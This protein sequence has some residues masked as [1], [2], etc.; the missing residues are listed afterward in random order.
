MGMKDMAKNGEKFDLIFLDADKEN[1]DTYYEICLSGADRNGD[2][3][4]DDGILAN[5]GVILADNS[6]CALLYDETDER[7]KALHRFNRRVAMDVRVEQVLLTVREGITMIRRKNEK[8]RNDTESVQVQELGEPLKSENSK[9]SK[10]ISRESVHYYGRLASTAHIVVLTTILPIFSII[11]FLI[12]MVQ[13][14]IRNKNTELD[15]ACKITYHTRLANKKQITMLIPGAHFGKTLTI[16]RSIKAV[17]PNVRIILTDSPKYALN[18]ARFSRY[19]DAFEIVTAD[20]VTHPQEYVCELAAIA[21][22]H[23]VT[24]FLPVSQPAASFA[25][26][27]ACEEMTKIQDFSAAYHVPAALCEILDDKFLFCQI[28]EEL[29]K[30]DPAIT[31]PKTVLIETENG[32]RAL[33]ANLLNEE[34]KS[35]EIIKNLEY[36]CLHRLDLFTMP[37]TEGALGGYLR[38]LRQ[39]GNGICS[40]HPWIAQTKLEGNEYSAA[41]VIRNS[42]VKLLTITRSSASQL[43]FEHIEHQGIEK[44]VYAFVKQCN[45]AEKG[46]T[47]DLIK[48]G[49][50][51]INM[52]ELKLENCQ[53]CFDFIEE[54]GTTTVFPIECNTRVHSQLSVFSTSELGKTI[55]GA[56]VLGGPVIKDVIDDDT[57][58]SYNIPETMNYTGSTIHFGDEIFKN[59]FKIQNYMNVDRMPKNMPCLMNALLNSDDADL[60]VTDPLPFFV[61]LHMQLPSLL[62]KNLVKGKPWKK[63]DFCIGKVVELHGE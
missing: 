53:L 28:C 43:H 38:K 22:K 17:D 3:T 32:V 39:D 42:E 1:Y 56:A 4:V 47:Q 2:G 33:N 12:K 23:N 51:I 35:G 40:Q 36:D 46:S 20:P 27:L 21:R 11:F 7:R 30:K 37:C 13:N 18:G 15:L 45:S 5:N 29:G 48:L 61:K 55:L 62:M 59:V 14:M 58:K 19:C 50:K 57:I 31:A 44:W 8:D 34:E 54:V 10:E 16:M 60:D 63:I 49:K 52:D 41:V 24:G 25:D 26:S 9:E 6:A